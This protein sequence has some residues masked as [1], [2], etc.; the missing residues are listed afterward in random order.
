MLERN[1]CHM[2]FVTRCTLYETS[3]HYLNP[4]LKVPWLPAAVFGLYQVF[5]FAA[6]RPAADT[7]VSRHRRMITE[8]LALRLG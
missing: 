2:V 5:I 7:E 3:Q 6:L 1:C 4:S 8:L